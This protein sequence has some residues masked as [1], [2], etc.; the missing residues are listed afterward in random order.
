MSGVNQNAETCAF[1]VGVTGYM[2]LDGATAEVVRRQVQLALTFLRD[3]KSASF[4]NAE[5]Q[6]STT[7]IELA[8]QLAAPGVRKLN[9][10]Y[11]NFLKKWKPL[12][13][14]SII[15]LSALA[16]G[17]DSVVAAAALDM[18]IE[19]I[20]ALPFPAEIY[21]QST[22]FNWRDATPA[23]NEQRVAT[24]DNLLK[25]C[26][27]ESEFHV[28]LKSDHGLTVGERHQQAMADLTE[29]DENGKPRRYARYYA[30]GEYLANYC[31]LLIAIW[32]GKQ[33]KSTEGTSAIVQS[34]L[35]GPRSD[36]LPTT[37]ELTLPN[38]GPLLHILANKAGEPATSVTTQ[39]LPKMRFLHP[40]VHEQAVPPRTQVGE[41][42]APHQHTNAKLQRDRLAT[43]LRLSKNLVRFNTL[44]LPDW[45]QRNRDR[46]F[47]EKRLERSL[48]KEGL[49]FK[50]LKGVCDMRTRAADATAWFDDWR[51]FSLRWLFVF[52]VLAAI[53]LHF[54]A[55]WHIRESQGTNEELAVVKTDATGSDHAHGKL[56]NDTALLEKDKKTEK[57]TSEENHAK[58]TETAK[59]S[60]HHDP[61]AHFSWFRTCAGLLAFVLASLAIMLFALAIVFRFVPRAEDSRALSEGLRVQFYWNLIGLGKSVSA[62]YMQRQRSELE[63]IR[64]AIRTTSM[65]YHWWADQFRELQPEAKLAIL[66][67]VKTKWV[68]EQLGYF[69]K[70]Y[71]RHEHW[72][73]SGH[74]LGFVLS[75]TAIISFIVWW[76]ESCAFKTEIV[77]KE[78]LTTYWFVALSVLLVIFVISITIR[79]VKWVLKRMSQPKTESPQPIQK[80]QVTALQKCVA[81]IKKQC[82]PVRTKGGLDPGH[83]A[84]EPWIHW[85]VRSTGNK[86]HGIFGLIF[87]LL[88]LLVPTMDSTSKT[89][90]SAWRLFL[91]RLCNFLALLPL[92]ASIAFPLVLWVH[93]QADQHH[94]WPSAE[95]LGIICSGVL[96][97]C[98]AMSIAW[99]EK[100]MHSEMSYQYNTMA[101][102]FQHASHRMSRLLD[103]L[104][105]LYKQI[106]QENRQDEKSKPIKQFETKVKETQDFLYSLGVEALDENAEWL[107][108]HRARP[109]EPVMAG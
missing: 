3:G 28:L 49:F 54:F 25:R 21:R 91:R 24:F 68:D 69:A 81:W 47:S 88:D 17:A 64:A 33:E 101:G 23:E 15:L 9:S 31:H 35:S 42:I 67:S 99:V 58:A 78:C 11:S 8:E 43:F 60:E 44:V 90:A 82:T 79:I 80:P 92:A 77:N 61:C 4:P 12:E 75:L 106:Q 63:W 55:H 41:T 48:E 108:L 107:L 29:N 50:R 46:E 26:K 7:R 72:L 34:R 96:L 103:E 13:K 36:I 38:G 98:G 14:T 85:L 83:P 16:P 93:G 52:T 37:S 19:V 27:K 86:I 97:L 1:L 56:A 73:H 66:R 109:L 84:Y 89:S 71:H 45:A 30:A 20:A 74:K 18:G 22:T 94:D 59:K 53:S 10:S 6:G 39:A 95:N 2:R 87:L 40:Y 70:T 51:K 62:N 105:A 76:W 104:S 57:A 5:Q 32:D 102:L 65:P 100:N